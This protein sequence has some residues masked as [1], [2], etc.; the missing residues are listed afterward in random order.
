MDKMSPFEKQMYLAVTGGEIDISVI[1]D[2]VKDYKDWSDDDAF[3]KHLL[4]IYLIDT[5]L[6]WLM[7]HS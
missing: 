4:A 3:Y 2:L 5:A 7:Y 1:V 6:Y